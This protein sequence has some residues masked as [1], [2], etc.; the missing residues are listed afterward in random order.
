M[1]FLLHH[2]SA[3]TFSTGEGI[4]GGMRKVTMKS[5]KQ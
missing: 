5:W 3:K 2:N 4:S 1:E